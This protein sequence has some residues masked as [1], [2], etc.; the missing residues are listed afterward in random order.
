MSSSRTENQIH[1]E[2]VRQNTQSF[3]IQF[4]VNS[5]FTPFQTLFLVVCV[6]KMKRN[7]AQ[8]K[9]N[10]TAASRTF[11]NTNATNTESDD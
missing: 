7:Q 10:W 2:K 1:E 5:I 3:K 9:R 11:K 8:Y 6:I 4:E